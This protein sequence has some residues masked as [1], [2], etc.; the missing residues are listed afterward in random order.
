MQDRMGE[1][2]DG[3]L[4]FKDKWDAFIKTLP[5]R[6]IIPSPLDGKHIVLEKLK[7]GPPGYYMAPAD[8]NR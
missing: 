4:K 6:I 5:E 7:G 3:D 8:F 1:K 2:N